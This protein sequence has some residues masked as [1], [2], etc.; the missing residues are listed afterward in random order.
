MDLLGILHHAS[1]SYL[2]PIINDT[3]TFYKENFL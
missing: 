3:L 1:F 2:I